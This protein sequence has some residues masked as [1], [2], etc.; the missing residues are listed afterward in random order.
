M[1]YPFL[2]NLK[3]SSS[4]S[5]SKLRLPFTHYMLQIT[6]SLTLSTFM[7]QRFHSLPAS[8]LR[9]DSVFYKRLLICRGLCSKLEL[10]F[11]HKAPVYSLKQMMLLVME[12]SNLI[13]LYIGPNP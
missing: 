8:M 3:S 7:L 4:S 13:I 6:P 2:H 1:I 10:S 9:R 11:D 12:K 5:S